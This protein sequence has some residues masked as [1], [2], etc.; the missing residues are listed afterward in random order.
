MNDE[1]QN[2]ETSEDDKEWENALEDFSPADNSKQGDDSKKTDDIDDDSKKTD[3]DDGKQ[4]DG[5]SDDKKDSE[6][7]DSDNKPD[8]PKEEDLSANRSLRESRALQ[9]ESMADEKAMKEDIRSE[10]FSDVDNV[11]KDADGDPIKTIED[12]QKLVN[13][14]TQQ[15]FTEEEAAMWL[16][17]AQKNLNETIEQN[18]KMVEE[19]ADTNLSLKDQADNI[20]EKYGELLKSMPDLAKE[21]QDAF[22]DTLIK[23][24]KT[25]IITKA[26]VS[27][28]KFYDTAL[29]GYVKLAEQMEAKAEADAKAGKLKQENEKLHTRS[30]REDIYSNSGQDDLSK[31]DKE[32]ASA[33]KAVYNN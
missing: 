25:G 6:E 29:R 30:D 14:R 9:R 19:I 8:Q 3:N 31:E 15:L 20:R 27:L 22:F 5:T 2:N 17:A 10:M 7:K 26:P 16:L 4:D 1:G 12:V 33:A 32:W 23:D 18:E 21:V 28:E 11:L 24:E 13:P